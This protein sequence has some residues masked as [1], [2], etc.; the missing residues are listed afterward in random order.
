MNQVSE[1][2][3][4]ADA[5]RPGLSVG[6]QLRRLVTGKKYLLVHSGGLTENQKNVILKNIDLK[7]IPKGKVACFKVSEAL[8]DKTVAYLESLRL[9]EIRIFQNA[10]FNPCRNLEKLKVA[11]VDY[12]RMMPQDLWQFARD[13]DKVFQIGVLVSDYCNL[14][15]IMCPFFSEDPKYAFK[16]SRSASMPRYNLELNVFKKLLDDITAKGK[17]S[18]RFSANGE[19]FMNPRFMEMVKLSRD[20]GHEV[21]I[22]T[23]GQLLNSSGIRELAEMGVQYLMFSIEGIT[24]PSYERVRVGGSFEKIVSV[25]EECRT[26]KEQGKA[27]WEIQVYYNDLDE[28]A[29]SHDEICNFFKGRADNV[30][31]RKPFMDLECREFKGLEDLPFDGHRYCFDILTYPY[32][33]SSGEVLPCCVFSNNR[34]MKSYS[35]AM[36][37]RDHSFDEILE[38]YKQLAGEHDPEFSQLCTNC[39]FWQHSYRSKQTCSDPIFSTVDLKKWGSS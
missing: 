31:I 7:S 21:I 27:V 4:I 30:T 37:I 17:C 36:N 11:D 10:M 1:I 18:I 32:L 14:K 26:L 13:S 38:R 8:G 34:F 28:L 24:K 19:P 23:N 15:C 16:E 6:R 22:N 35:W 5:L 25:L 3:H 9:P 29:F 20:R 39:R 2:I 12:I 33:L